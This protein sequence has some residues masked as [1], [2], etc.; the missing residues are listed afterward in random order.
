M[1][2]IFGGSVRSHFRPGAQRV[3]RLVVLPVV[4]CIVAS[5][6]LHS[7]ESYQDFVKRQKEGEEK[8]KVA[9]AQYKD[10]VTVQYQ[11]FAERE[12][13]A[14]KEYVDDIRKRWGKEKTKTSTNK[15]W[16]SYDG[17]F[18]ARRSVDFEKGQASV[19]VQ[20]EKGLPAPEVRKRVEQQ[21]V[22]MITDRGESDPLEATQKAP[23]PTQVLEG[24]LKTGTGGPVTPGNAAAYAGEVL[25][26]V[27]VRQ[28]PVVG[29]DG[30]SRIVARVSF[31]LVPDHIRVRAETYHETVAKNSLRFGVEAPLVF[32]VI[33]TESCFNPRARSSAPAYGLMQLVPQSGARAAHMYVYGEDKLL[34]PDHLY[35][36]SNNVELGSGYLSLLMTKYFKDVSDPLSRSYCAIAAYNTGPGNVATAFTG[37]KDVPEAV[38]RINGMTPEQVFARMRSNLPYAETR[39]YIA[40]VSGRVKLYAD[41]K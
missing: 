3:I 31:P 20:V 37:K 36:P 23:S 38:K 26:K 30:S 13:Q 8:E 24:Q 34:G 14:F 16:V 12:R 32:A 6:A 15:E 35:N 39:D 10:S 1:K 22:K 7:Q 28:E 2:R 5:T 9:F 29:G 11:R 18:G 19:E 33:H 25:N 17:D 41:W 21:I 4:A 40:S 27:S